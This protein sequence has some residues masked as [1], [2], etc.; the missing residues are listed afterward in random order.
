M[1]D[2]HPQ[3]RL[4]LIEADSAPAEAR[5]VF[6]RFI[7]ERGK[8]PNLFRAVAHNPAIVTTLEAHMRAVMG[9]GTVPTLLKE[10]L[11]VRV[12]EINACEY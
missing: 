7:N 3:A 6:E 2:H 9:P 10:L 5:P 11:S 8:V 4:P 1:S 12:S